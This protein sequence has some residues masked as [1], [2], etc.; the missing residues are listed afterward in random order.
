MAVAKIV[1][2]GAGMQRKRIIPALGLAALTVAFLLTTG[3]N[4]F[5]ARAD[6]KSETFDSLSSATQRRLERGKINVGDTH[7][8]VYIALGNPDE[9]R[10]ITTANGQERSWIYKSYWQQYEGTAWTGWHRV[11]VPA[12]NGRGY[13]VYHEPMA[14]DLYRTHI[15]EVIRVNFGGETVNS[16]D[17]QKR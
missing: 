6:E 17:Q 1:A 7:D 11:I 13:L 2:Y 9:K 16:V 4:T 12:A 8:M 10:E 15:D 14:R 5:K 3:C